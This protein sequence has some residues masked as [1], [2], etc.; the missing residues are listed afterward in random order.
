MNL[1]SR[2]WSKKKVS[3]VFVPKSGILKGTRKFN[4]LS[5]ARHFNHPI[6]ISEIFTQPN[7]WM[8]HA[9]DPKLLRSPLNNAQYVLGYSKDE[10]VDYMNSPL[11]WST[12]GWNV[13]YWWPSRLP[14]AHLPTHCHSRL[15]L[16]PLSARTTSSFRNIRDKPDKPKR[17]KFIIL[18]FCNLIWHNS[19][20]LLINLPIAIRISSSLSSNIKSQKT[21]KPLTRFFHFFP[22]RQQQYRLDPTL[23]LSALDTNELKT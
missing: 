16:T 22:K 23:R 14:F 3:F 19:T 20:A 13:Y 12:T 9:F 2:W 1:F 10:T 17:F 7:S 18:Q 11:R 8:L 5:S 6:S 15:N 21:E 4:F